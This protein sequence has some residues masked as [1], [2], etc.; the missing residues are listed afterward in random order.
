VNQQAKNF[1]RP[2]VR[3]RV[4]SIDCPSR[5]FRAHRPAAPSH[6]PNFR[7]NRSWLRR[8]LSQPEMRSLV[9]EGSV[10]SV[11]GYTCGGPCGVHFPTRLK[12]RFLKVMIASARPLIAVSKTIS[13]FGSPGIVRRRTASSTLSP[14]KANSSKT[15]DKFRL[16]LYVSPL[17]VSYLAT[18][19]GRWDETRADNRYT[20]PK[21]KQTARN[22][23]CCTRIDP[24]PWIS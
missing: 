16:R 2:C 17:C 8:V 20:C 11:Y 13:S 3:T 7:L 19:L 1:T 12:S 14:T 18:L 15:A 10:A 21:P 22:S 24:T 5:K 4:R 6:R 23:W 9:I